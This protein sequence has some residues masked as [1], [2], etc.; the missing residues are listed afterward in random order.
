MRRLLLWFFGIGIGLIIITIIIKLCIPLF[1]SDLYSKSMEK[2][3]LS[4]IP[5]DSFTVVGN[6]NSK[7]RNQISIFD[8]GIQRNYR[9]FIYK[10]PIKNNFSLENIIGK[11]VKDNSI[12]AW[13]A[14]TVIE[15]GI[16]E[17]NYK[18]GKPPKAKNIL[19]SY[20]GNN[21]K[22]VAQNDSILSFS[23]NFKDFSIS[24]NKNNVKDIYGETILNYPPLNV[25][26]LKHN[27]GLYLLLM[28]INE[29][30]EELP[31]DML[32]NLVSR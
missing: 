22:L 26:F 28:T 2:E 31:P 6:Y 32:Y 14:Y 21:L 3:Y 11:K 27:K 9:L 4:L 12:N 7:I 23:L 30:G 25:L 15:K 8:Y 10:I 24:Y 17:L 1:E 5:Q 18:S 29:K 20:N 13:K 19:F 16:L